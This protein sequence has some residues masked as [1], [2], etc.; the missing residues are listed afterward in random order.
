MITIIIYTIKSEILNKMFVLASITLLAYLSVFANASVNDKINAGLK[1]ISLAMY[2]SYVYSFGAETNF[3]YVLMRTNHL[4]NYVLDILPELTN[5]TESLILMNDHFNDKIT[6]N[7][8]IYFQLTDPRNILKDYINNHKLV[9]QIENEMIRKKFTDSLDRI[10]HVQNEF[11]EYLDKP[12]MNHK[13]VL[14]QTCNTTNGMK[15]V[16]TDLHIEIVDKDGNNGT[17]NELLDGGVS[18]CQDIKNY[19]S[20]TF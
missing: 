3:D 19:Y 10:Y 20:D 8:Q 9:E 16:F 13:N 2:D 12:D 1:P 15:D 18:N 7:G 6:I 4:V 5:F 17:F 14:T 11:Y